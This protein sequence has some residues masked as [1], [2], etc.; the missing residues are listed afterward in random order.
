M[1]IYCA[2]V[3]MR[4][5]RSQDLA[6]LL[7]CHCRRSLNLQPHRLPQVFKLWLTLIA[8]DQTLQAWIH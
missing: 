6:R 8:T 1:T 2:Q 4:I 7:S 3:N 5:H